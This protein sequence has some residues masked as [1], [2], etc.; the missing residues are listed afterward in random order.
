LNE[1]ISETQSSNGSCA[2]SSTSSHSFPSNLTQHEA[3]IDNVLTFPELQEDNAQFE[4]FKDASEVFMHKN[5]NSLAEKFFPPLQVNPNR[6]SLSSM[7]LKKTNSATLTTKQSEN[8]S[9]LE[10]GE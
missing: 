2:P 3:E 8:I 9:N 5:F 4:I 7:F 1:T 10:H 6:L